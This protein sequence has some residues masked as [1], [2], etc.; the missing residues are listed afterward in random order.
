MAGTV[1]A[2]AAR[3]SGICEYIAGRLV[4]SRL[5]ASD[6]SCLA[7]YG[8]WDAA[9]GGFEP[10]MLKELLGEGGPAYFDP[11]PALSVAGLWKGRVPVAFPVGDN[12]AGFHGLVA[13][14]RTSCLVNLGTSGQLSFFSPHA[15]AVEGMD[16]RPFLGRAWIQVGASLCGGKAYEIVEEFLRQAA[17]LATGLKVEAGAVYEAMGRLASGYADDAGRAGASGGRVPLRVVPTFNGSRSDPH[18]RGAILD[19]G[20]DNLDPGNLVRAVLAGIVEELREFS[21]ELGAEFDGMRGIVA[22]GG[23]VRKV[24]A[25]PQVLADAFRLDVSVSGTEDGAAIG[26]ALIGAEAAGL[27]DAAARARIVSGLPAAIFRPRRGLA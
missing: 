11:A 10:G 27:I 15:R 3:I 2:S 26:A 12:Q 20:M 19:I 21:L 22:T 16:L 1:P 4:G 8:A 6:A 24:A 18:R 17:E 13:D 14:P 9:A 7:S 25:V 23:L 5:E